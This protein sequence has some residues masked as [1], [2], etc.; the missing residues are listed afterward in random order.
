MSPYPKIISFILTALCA[1]GLFAQ[2]SGS[3]AAARDAVKRLELLLDGGNTGAGAGRS[4]P[5]QPTK[6][7]SEPAWVNDPY[8]EYPRDRYITAVGYAASRGEAERKALAALTALFGQSIQSDFSAATIYSEAVSRGIVTVSENTR[9][10]DTVVTAAS[11]DT[12]IGAEIGKVWDDARGTV[13]AAAYMDRKKTADVYTELI[14]ANLQT[15]DALTA[16]S[17]AKKNTFD[18]YARYKL[19]AIMTGINTKYAQ[20]INHA[21]GAAAVPANLK[22]QDFYDL[23]TMNIVKNITVAVDVEGDRANR[24]RDAF[25]KVISGEGLRT[26][27]SNPPY[28]LE[29]SIDLSEVTFPNNQ[30]IYCRSVVS[31]NLIENETGAVLLPFS[32]TDRVGH[33]SYANAETSAINAAEKTIGEKY[34]AVLKGYLEGLLPGR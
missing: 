10:R 13:Y 21:S 11:L 8:R 7:G 34:P 15:I 6:G 19:A 26:R 31:A 33:T 28:V 20:V 2:S 32:I 4:A 16:M 27:G 14:Q 24:I 1:A 12:L 3:E 30:V 25:A 17:A 23:E 22:S 9:V 29:V 5:V 18:G